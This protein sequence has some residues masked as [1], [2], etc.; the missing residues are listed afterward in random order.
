MSLTCLRKRKSNRFLEVVSIAVPSHTL[1]RINLQFAER[2]GPAD[3]FDSG[4]SSSQNAGDALASHIH[5][6]FFIDLKKDFRFQ[7]R[8]ALK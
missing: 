6:F 7:H 5:F 8:V 1:P 4:M 3:D 2:G